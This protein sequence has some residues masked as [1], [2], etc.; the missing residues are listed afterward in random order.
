MRHRHIDIPEGVYPVA[1][2]HS[3]IERGGASDVMDLLRAI[4]DDPNGETADAA[5][6]AARS[7][8]VYGYPALLVACITAWR[9]ELAP[10]PA[11]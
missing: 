7:S 5:L 11:V 1:A 8:R 2:I 3:I 10:K 6:K 4:H 9:E